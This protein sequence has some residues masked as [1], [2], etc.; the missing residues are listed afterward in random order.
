MYICTVVNTLQYS[1]TFWRS[2]LGQMNWCETK[3]LRIK[4]NWMI[5]TLPHGHF[6]VGSRVCQRR[7]SAISAV[8]VSFNNIGHLM[9]FLP[10]QLCSS[11]AESTPIVW[12]KVESYADCVWIYAGRLLVRI[13]LEFCQVFRAPGESIQYFH[14]TSDKMLV[15]MKMY[16]NLK[17]GP[18]SP[19][20]CRNALL[21]YLAM[22]TAANLNL[23]LIPSPR[24]SLAHKA[25]T[26]RHR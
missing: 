9:L 24:D 17:H 10:K 12:R 18:W 3:Q 19:E 13:S 16:C 7:F 26:N 1:F 6:Y 5:P 4:V 25:L 20:S 14:K 8:L 11:P 22:C 23:C 21:K 15:V 2:K